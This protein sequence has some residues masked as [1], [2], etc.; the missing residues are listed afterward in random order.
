MKTL[1][2]K[3][4]LLLFLL[5]SIIQVSACKCVY[6]TLP[7][8]YQSADFAGI[9]KIL[10]VYDENIE[11][12][13]YKADIEI[14][15][16]YKGTIFKTI[17][18]RGLIGNSYSGACEVNVLPNE[19]YL[20]F[21]NRYDNTSSISSCT[22][23]SKL[24]NKPTKAEKLWLKN[25]EKV[26]TYLDNHKFSF[27]QFAR[28]YDETQTGNKSDLSKISGFKPK[29]PFAIYKVKINEMSKV[30]EITPVTTFGSKDSIIENILKTN[31]IVS[32]TTSFW[33][34][35]PKEALLFLSYNKNDPYGEVISCD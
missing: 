8:N 13:T 12:R 15:K 16:M 22:P 2:K 9:I 6:E 4:S 29:Q 20:I 30:Q 28:C 34:P 3:L 27:I 32:A 10:K 35:N 24:E 18:V 23:K 1:M 19:R 25:Q 17:N 31:M 33:D 7:Q 26:F 11:Q 21:L 14:E 5:F